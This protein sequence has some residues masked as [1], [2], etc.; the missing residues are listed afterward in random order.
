MHIV[1]GQ[2]KVT[3][4]EAGLKRYL[5]LKILGA[6]VMI[7]IKSA[8]VLSS[9][10]CDLLLHLR[11][12]SSCRRYFETNWQLCKFLPFRAS[13]LNGDA[14]PSQFYSDTHISQ[15]VGP[16]ALKWHPLLRIRGL[17]TV[18]KFSSQRSYLSSLMSFF[19]GA[20]CRHWCRCFYGDMCHHRWQF[21]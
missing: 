3:D 16:V 8:K 5:V 11:A 13:I 12:D 15:W 9:S 4:S 6:P 18:E 14:H 1:C 7:W 21:L 19:N 2:S 10:Q 17:K 20:I